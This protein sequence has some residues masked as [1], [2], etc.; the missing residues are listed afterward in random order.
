MNLDAF[1]GFDYEPG[2]AEEET[3]LS[4]IPLELMKQSITEQFANPM[5]VGATDYVQAFETRWMIT[6]E[7]M[8]EENEEE[9]TRLYESFLSFMDHM[10]AES[11]SLGL[12]ELEDASEEDQL[13]QVHYVYRYFIINMKKNFSNFLLGYIDDHKEQLAACL[14]KKKDVTTVNLKQYIDD[15]DLITIIAALDECVDHIIH[16][17][18]TVDVF[19]QYARGEKAYLEAD[20]ID[21]MYEKFQ[22][23]GNFV[24]KYIDLLSEEYLVEIESKVRN[25]FLKRCRKK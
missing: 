3:L 1:R 11:L 9:Y 22:L 18:L 6:K 19:L 12:P 5:D 20:F 13:Q 8:D 2:D 4:E 7:A 17:D 25:K 16:E 15:D 23:T 14:P 10:F 21:E 24:K